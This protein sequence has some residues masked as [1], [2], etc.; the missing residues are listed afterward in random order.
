MF[1]I[2]TVLLVLTASR[3]AVAGAQGELVD[4]ASGLFKVKTRPN[5]TNDTGHMIM[6]MCSVCTNKKQ[7]LWVAVYSRV[8]KSTL[9][10]SEG[11]GGVA[12]QK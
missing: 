11:G 8:V 5:Y 9:L 2:L 1:A 12:V 6:I 10:L 3:I 7:Q 4:A